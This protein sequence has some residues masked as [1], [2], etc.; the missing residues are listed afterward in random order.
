MYFTENTVKNAVRDLIG[1]ADH[2][3]KIWFV[4]KAMGLTKSNEIIVDT[5]NSTPHLKKLFHSGNA[6]GSFFVPFAHTSRFATMRNDAARSIIQ[7]NC[8]KWIDGT[9]TGVN[10]T[11][12][13]NFSQTSSGISVSVG[14]QYPLGLGYG[15]EG[16]ARDSNQRVCIPILQFAIWL[17]AQSEIK[18]TGK[19]LIIDAMKNE[20]NLDD[21]ECELVFVEKDIHIDFQSHPISDEQLQSICAEAFNDPITIEVKSESKTDYIKRVK[22]MITISEKPAWVTSSP[23]DQLKYLNEQGE[24]AILLYGPPRTGKTR[25]IDEV[26]GRDNAD[27]CTIQLHE[28]WGYENL[29]IG[30]FPKEDGS[31]FK[32]KD[33]ALLTAIKE[34]KKIIVLEEVNRTHLSQALGEIFSLIEPAY[35]GEKY[36]IVLPNGESFFIPEDTVFFFTMNTID[37]STEDVDDALIGRMSSVFFPPRIEDLNSI[38]TK[39]GIS[40]EKKENIL[41]VFNTILASYP[42]GHGYFAGIKDEIPFTKYYLHRIRPVL[43]NHFEA[44]KPELI[45][46]IDNT[47]DTLFSGDIK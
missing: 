40:G 31:G 33:G 45:S 23:V 26:Y 29:I 30:F 18:D 37:T 11:S 24:K 35:R 22:N 43:S 12:F 6:D 28:G 32:W 5:A 1:T 25:A 14:R 13:L 16:F 20:L 7:T 15:V 36:S 39:S 21:S 19:Q 34:N 46:Q 27:R 41:T 3:L 47:I 42:L 4:L 9:V 17:F 8:K 2:M 38:L 44:F 10:P